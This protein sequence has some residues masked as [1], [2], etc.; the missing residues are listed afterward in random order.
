MTQAPT[1]LKRSST[2]PSSY[3]SGVPALKVLGG[4]DSTLGKRKRMVPRTMPISEAVMVSQPRPIQLLIRS[5]RRVLPV[6]GGALAGGAGL[7]GRAGFGG[8]A[9]TAVADGLAA[10]AGV[11]LAGG[12]FGSDMRIV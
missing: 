12:V 5:H 8:A 11:S 9:V 7:G 1:V 2:L 3:W 4:S 10:A 6:L